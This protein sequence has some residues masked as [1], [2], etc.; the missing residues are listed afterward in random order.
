MTQK[1]ENQ[2]YIIKVIT[3]D[4]TELIVEA[5]KWKDGI[6]PLKL[7]EK[8]GRFTRAFSNLNN[9]IDDIEAIAEVHGKMVMEDAQK[10]IA[11]CDIFMKEVYPRLKAEDFQNYYHEVADPII[12]KRNLLL[13]NA[14]KARRNYYMLEEICSRVKPEEAR[15][16]NDV[17]QYNEAKSKWD[18]ISANFI[19]DVLNMEDELDKAKRLDFKPIY[20]EML[21]GR[22]KDIADSVI[23]DLS[24]IME[25]KE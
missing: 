16:E 22:L 20:I 6:I 9:V 1:D 23:K 14:A 19:H 5:R 17:K 15:Y 4:L 2:A 11:C 7:A 3:I 21:L 8:V 12:R 10:L 18:K 13:E 24:V 25:G